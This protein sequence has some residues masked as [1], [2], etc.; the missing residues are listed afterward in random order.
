MFLKLHKANNSFESLVHNQTYTT[1]EN[2][3][4]YKTAIHMQRI[5]TGWI[6][7]KFLLICM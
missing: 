7:K 6:Q 4:K 3:C 1:T 2:N 5:Y